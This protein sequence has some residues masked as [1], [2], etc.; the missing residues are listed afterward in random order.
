MDTCNWTE[1]LRSFSNSMSENPY[2]LYF[3][4]FVRLVLLFY[5]KIINTT[6]SFDNTGVEVT[7]F[8]YEFTFK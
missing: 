6:G 2:L 3:Y 1:D 4:C 7:R 5:I 8:E